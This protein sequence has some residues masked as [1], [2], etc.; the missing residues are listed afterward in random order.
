MQFEIDAEFQ[1]LSRAFERAAQEYQVALAKRQR[2][3]AQAD[4]K[5]S[6]AG[7]VRRPVGAPAAVQI[8]QPVSGPGPV[9][10]SAGRPARLYL[11]PIL[12]WVELRGRSAPIPEGE[13]EALPDVDAMF[14]RISMELYWR[15]KNRYSECKKALDDYVDR[16]KME[17]HRKQARSALGQ[18][19]NLQLLGIQADAD[20]LIAEA[21]HEVEAASENAW[22]LYQ[23]SPNPKSEAAILLLLS[24]LADAQLAGAEGPAS[25]QLQAEADRLVTSGRLKRT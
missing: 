4:S 17:E 20:R 5:R 19:A 15:A 12:G 14:D 22:R 23:N 1:R 9:A 11:G 25:Q 16:R 24:A 18:A 2:D 21:V 6:L 8:P 13:A 10:S 3:R 7:Q